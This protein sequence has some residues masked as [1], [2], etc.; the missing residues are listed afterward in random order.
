V[1]GRYS[2]QKNEAS[3]QV[4]FISDRTPPKVMISYL[5]ANPTNV[6]PMFISIVFDEELQTPPSL[7]H[8]QIA[9]GVA[10]NLIGSGRN[11]S[12]EIAPASQTA[13]ISIQYSADQVID[14]VGNKNTG[15]NIL[16]VDF[17]SNRPLPTL[18]SASPSIVNTS[19]ITVNVHFSGVVTGLD[20]NDL[21]LVN[22]TASNLT[23]S[24]DSYS[25]TLTALSPGNFSAQVKDSAVVDG[26]L[27]PSLSSAVLSFL[28]DT[29]GPTFTL[30]SS[31]SNPTDQLQV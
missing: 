30:S 1:E 10:S 23:G 13:T 4:S 27:N 21:L 24:G 3:N 11:Y 29:V 7:S 16:S 19:A 20:L 15:S 12:L 22:A 28:Y 2:L 18:S 8:L 25:F 26:A 17:N 5:G 6:S 14:L 9:N 31:V